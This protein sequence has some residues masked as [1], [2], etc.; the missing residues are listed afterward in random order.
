MADYVRII[1]LAL[2]LSLVLLVGTSI[3]DTI[4]ENEEGIRTDEQTITELGAAGVTVS[5]SDAT[6]YNEVV[7]DSR[8]NAV[9]FNGADDS[10]LTADSGFDISSDNTWTVHQGVINITNTS[11]TQILLTIGD[12]EIVLLYV[13]EGANDNFSAVRL[14]TADSWQVNVSAPSPNQHNFVT[15]T[16]NGSNMTIFR[17]GTVG[18]ST[19]LS[20]S[21]DAMD[22]STVGNCE[23]V[24]D[25]TRTDDDVLNLT[26]RTFI[27]NNPVAPLNGSNQT[28]RIM[29][30]KGSGTHVNIFWTSS[31]ASISNATWVSGFVG[32]VLDEKTGPLDITG[33]NDYR[34]DFDGPTIEPVSGG[35][36]DG[37]PAAF[38]TYDRESA[39]ND[40][41]QA[42][43]DF[44]SLASI[45]PLLLITVAIVVIVQ[46][47]RA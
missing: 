18:D 19:N 6:G 28:G 25:E 24:L 34:W 32:H 9:E 46:R 20:Q 37:A 43:S 41:I 5:I 17:N 30:D 47:M 38:I 31:D 36:L 42:W 27:Q 35:A 16:R 11:K 2:S 44:T 26:Q 3:I 1:V 33:G 29:Y 40:I 14:G 39:K 12:P 4:S 13:D 23:C 10:V 22:I 45:V 8:G 7:K 21:G 15:L